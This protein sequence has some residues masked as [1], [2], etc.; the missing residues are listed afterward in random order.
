M[1]RA[2]DRLAERDACASEVSFSW[3]Q[4]RERQPRAD[5]QA[6]ESHERKGLAGLVI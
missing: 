5:G 4:P 3:L 2:E 6:E 1:E